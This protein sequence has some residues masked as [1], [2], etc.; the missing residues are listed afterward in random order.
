MRMRIQT[1]KVKKTIIH[2]IQTPKSTW[3]MSK[4]KKKKGS[5]LKLIDQIVRRK[6]LLLFQVEKRILKTIN[7][8]RVIKKKK[9]MM[10]LSKKI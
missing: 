2:D 7:L 1:A 8:A 6:R 10:K 5:K 9:W 3:K 4:M